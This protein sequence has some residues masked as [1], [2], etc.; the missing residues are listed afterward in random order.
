MIFEFVIF[1]IKVILQT[2]SVGFVVSKAAFK[3]AFVVPF[4]L[5]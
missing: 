3:N 1:S 2:F 4:Q 5:S